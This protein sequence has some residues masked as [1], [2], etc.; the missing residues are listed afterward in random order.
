MSLSHAARR[1]RRFVTRIAGAATAALIAASALAGC[2]A[3]ASL[4]KDE[5]TFL[6]WDNAEV[7][8]PV[9]AEFE[10]ENPD[11]T[12]AVQYAPPVAQ[13]IQKLQTQ[14]GSGTAPDV[15]IITA[16][17]KKQLIDSEL[18]Q[19]LS[20]ESWADNLA[21]AARETYTRDGKLYGSAISSW[22]GGIVVN[23]QILAEAG[24]TEFPTNWDDFLELCKQLK[25]AG[26]TPY[27]E[28]VEGVT[29]TLGA[30]LGLQ[31]EAY[32]STMDQQIW[33]G[34]LTFE[35][36]WTPAVE[37]WNQL[38]EEGILDSSAAGLKFD[39]VL[40]EFQQGRVAMMSTGS[41]G[42]SSIADGAPDL[43][44][45]FKAVPGPQ[46]EPYWLGAVSPG[47]AINAKAKNAEGAKVFLE[48]MSTEPG[49]TAFQDVT[50]TITTTK[51]FEPSLPA[52]LD[53]LVP[54]VREGAF[55]LPVVSWIDHNDVLAV[56]ATALVQQLAA[57]Q[58]SPEDVGKGLD[59][60]LASLR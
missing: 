14:L 31:N 3:G 13:Y 46:S 6:S 39:Q 41:W 17:N 18:V 28:P 49:V 25:A 37:A 8:E 58:I 5:I 7:M 15:F 11:Y 10:K 34:D 52:E 45:T 20:G 4:D 57:G 60:K 40:Q 55:Y 35:E 38:L 24:V 33:D 26:V 50:K 23:E 51:D 29:V 44:F 43:D 19:D 2:A 9:I 22:G 36:A 30:L 1:P 32:D 16:E 48:W 47:L 54:A 59:A 53:E 56:E 21:D 12:V 42:V 27:L